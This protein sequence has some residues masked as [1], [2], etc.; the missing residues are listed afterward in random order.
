M[1]TTSKTARSETVRGS[2]GTVVH[3][4]EEAVAALV[5]DAREVR[6]AATVFE[7][8]AAEAEQRYAD[9]VATTLAEMELDLSIARAALD[10][11]LAD[12]TEELH[13]S[14]QDAADA[15]RTWLDELKVQSGLARM[16][17]RDRA[18]IMV[19]RIDQS[20]NA[21]RRAGSR[22]MDAV[23]GDLGEMRQIALDGI[24]EVRRALAD[25]AGALRGLGD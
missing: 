12:S 8:S 22:V 15:G 11:Q 4:L 13:R 10:A 1:S 6:A 16:E 18:G 24:G 20:S 25:T 9:E 2:T 21:V 5:E 14:V 19:R 23:E 7:G 3:P 17:A